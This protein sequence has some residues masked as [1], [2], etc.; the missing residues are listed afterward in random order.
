VLLNP[1]KTI[2]IIH[3]PAREIGNEE[4][5]RGERGERERGERES[6]KH[7][8]NVQPFGR[9]NDD[10][11]MISKD[12]FEVDSAIKLLSPADYIQKRVRKKEK[13]KEC[14]VTCRIP[15]IKAWTRSQFEFPKMTF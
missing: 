14:K 3:K 12:I 13:K 1:H 15:R 9:S 8:T 11:F 6:E 10:S 2:T 4:R 5:E 7:T